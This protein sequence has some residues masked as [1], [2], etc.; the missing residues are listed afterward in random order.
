MLDQFN[1]L[2]FHYHSPSEHTIDGQTYPLEVH[3][4]HKDIIGRFAV[5]AFFYDV[6]TQCNPDLDP[7]VN[8]ISAIPNPGSSVPISVK[9][10]YPIAHHFWHYVGSLTTPPCL[11]IVEWF[12]Y[13]DVQPIC[14]RQLQAIQSV[15]LSPNNRPIQNLNNR[16]VYVGSASTHTLSH[17]VAAVCVALMAA[18]WL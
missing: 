2:Q 17:V 9:V 10:H 12:V 1:L 7:I 6:T 18:C 4:V 14:S 16:T 15:M 11:E 8:A 13:K 5:V 3:Y